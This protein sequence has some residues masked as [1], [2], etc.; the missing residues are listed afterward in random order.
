MS[1]IAASGASVP[2]DLPTIILGLMTLA[3]TSAVGVLIAAFFNRKKTSAESEKTQA[4]ARQIS[5]ATATALITTL[6]EELDRKE[7]EHTQELREMRE[8]VG[9]C[10]TR[11]DVAETKLSAAEARAERAEF[12]ANRLHEQVDRL[13]SELNRYKLRVMQLEK[14]LAD[15][16][17]EPPAWPEDVITQ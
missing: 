4:E 16:G 6:R 15:N 12:V 17:L 14:H 10:R 8:E 13:S 7:A 1:W 2:L 11:L 5:Q 9:S 3:G